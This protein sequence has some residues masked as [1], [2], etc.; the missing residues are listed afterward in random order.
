MNAL[1]REGKKDVDNKFFHLKWQ[2]VARVI[3][4]LLQNEKDLYKGEIYDDIYK[5]LDFKNLTPFK[6][7]SSLSGKIELEQLFALPV[8]FNTR[9]KILNKRF[10]GYS[11]MPKK[12]KLDYDKI[13]Y[14]GG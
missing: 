9:E 14:Y 1:A 12:L 2:S 10:N 6:G 4:D 11:S 8:F 7:F 5:L 3:E 13:I